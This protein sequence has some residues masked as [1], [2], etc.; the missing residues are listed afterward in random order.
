MDNYGNLFVT[1]IKLAPFNNSF[2]ISFVLNFNREKSQDHLAEASGLSLRTIQRAEAGE[3]LSKETLLNITAT[4]NILVDEFNR[5][6]IRSGFL[7]YI[8]I[9]SLTFFL[10]F[11]YKLVI[12][13]KE[14]G[15]SK[16]ILFRL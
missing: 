14:S 1:V 8:L 12:V 13:W 6:N 16:S 11:Y 10:T 4:L 2:M 5:S 7:I 3:K 9:L 15:Y